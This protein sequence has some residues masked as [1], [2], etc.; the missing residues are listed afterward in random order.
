MIDAPK[1]LLKCLGQGSKQIVQKRYSK[2]L[3]E[4]FMKKVQ[5]RKK[6]F[7]SIIPIHVLEEMDSC[8]G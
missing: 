1:E 4:T 7:K 3:N 8:L 5:S 2:S 6:L